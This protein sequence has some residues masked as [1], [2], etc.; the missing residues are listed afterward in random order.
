MQFSKTNHG[1]DPLYL[2]I[3]AAFS[4]IALCTTEPLVW[5]GYVGV[6]YFYVMVGLG[7]IVLPRL[8]EGKY[9]QNYL[10]DVP[11]LPLQTFHIV[12]GSVLIYLGVGARGHAHTLFSE[13]TVQGMVYVLFGCAVVG[14]SGYRIVDHV[15]GGR[16][17][18]ARMYRKIE[19][20]V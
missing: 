18:F 8:F 14:Y 3:F 10:T 17:I 7:E 16:E 15:T 2:L 13:L 11:Y 6:F 4:I 12:Y 1:H 5:L 9:Y 19:T 20:S